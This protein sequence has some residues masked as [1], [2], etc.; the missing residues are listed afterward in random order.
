MRTFR[1]IERRDQQAAD[2]GD[3]P[4]GFAQLRL[5]IGRDDKRTG[6][7]GL[8]EL[9]E[10]GRDVRLAESGDDLGQCS[11]VFDRGFTPPA[12]RWLVGIE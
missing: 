6:I 10:I 1:Q 11:M 8:R 4:D 9:V 2:I 7:G 5:D 3:M 12:R